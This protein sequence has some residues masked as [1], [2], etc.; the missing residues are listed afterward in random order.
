MK[1][2]LTTR[3]ILRIESVVYLC[4][5]PPA[6][7]FILMAGGY[8][9]GRLAYALAGI[10]AAVVV[11]LLVGIIIR[12]KLLKPFQD[13]L[14]NEDREYT[15]EELLTLKGKALKYPMVESIQAA[16]RWVFGVATGII[17]QAV[18]IGMTPRE[19]ITWALVPLFMIPI[20]VPV[21]FYLSEL[22]LMKMLEDHRMVETHLRD[23]QGGRIGLFYRL[24][25]V[26]V[27]AAIAPTLT[28]GYFVLLSMWGQLANDYMSIVHLSIILLLLFGNIIYVLRQ[29][30]ESIRRE[31]GWTFYVLKKLSE[32]HLKENHVPM[33]SS[34]EIGYMSADINSLVDSLK[35]VTD[36]IHGET[37]GLLVVS[38]NLNSNSQK[39]YEDTQEQSAAVEEITAA[40]EELSS[41]TEKIAQNAKDQSGHSEEA[42]TSMIQLSETSDDIARQARHAADMAGQ[43]YKA[44]E[45]GDKLADETM[46][47]M[48]E[49]TESTGH[50][51]EAVLVISEVADQVNLLSLN[52]SIESA[53][54]GEHG[55]GFAVVAEEISKLADKT[56]VNSRQIIDMV[57][58]A[59][60]RVQMGQDAIKST[61]EAFH[62]ITTSIKETMQI[63]VGITL[64][65]SNQVTLSQEVREH[66]H[67]ATG[68]AE[69]IA[70]AAR[71]QA[72]TNREFLTSITNISRATQSITGFSD[73]VADMAKDMKSRA[74][75]LKTEIEFF[76]K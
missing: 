56:Q 73:H 38:E 43:T 10:T 35:H 33:L 37:R 74:E 54:A 13:F 75:R 48:L 27:S 21:N 5:V 39:L 16:L 51:S 7:Y 41:S 1:L 34:D 45:E 46:S 23:E 69:E 11:S 72:D 36:E 22:M 57:K 4:Q 19:F 67:T 50:I 29:A 53:R 24:V 55:R 32:G 31:L 20:S 59:V 8:T 52:A 3:L 76:E 28:L 15:S 68:M 70:R 40:M 71:E 6:I 64:D 63:V 58:E 18:M 17:V 12:I 44:A 61:T 42:D 14:E 60:S 66:L 30:T 47:R 9:L 49:I 26:V 62:K 2:N 65:A 25:F